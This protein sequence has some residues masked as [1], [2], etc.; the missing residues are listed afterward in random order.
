MEACRDSGT[1]AVLGLRFYDAAFADVLPDDAIPREVAA[2]L[3]ALDPLKP[4]PLE[5]VRALT[6]GAVQRWHGFDGR[7]AVFPAPSNPERC[8]DAALVVCG[9]LAASFFSATVR[10]FGTGL[11]VRLHR[12]AHPR[13]EFDTCGPP[14][15]ARA[16]RHGN[17]RRTHIP[18]PRPSFLPCRRAIHAASEAVP[19]PQNGLRSS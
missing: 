15:P 2:E 16:S 9:E 7:L 10:A 1:R 11:C 3:E 5:E 13:N 14:D 19:I 12:R 4:V 17:I 8:S 6:V 18:D